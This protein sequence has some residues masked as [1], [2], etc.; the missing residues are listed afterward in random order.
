MTEHSDV[1]PMTENFFN[2]RLS[3]TQS[4]PT[5][6]ELEE[7]MHFNVEMLNRQKS[8]KIFYTFKTKKKKKISFG[9]T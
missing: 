4:E 7:K 3:G 8:K 5:V 6:R 1:V 9:E 2:E